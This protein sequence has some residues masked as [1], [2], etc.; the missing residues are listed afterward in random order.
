MAGF[1]R[2]WA[3][4][5]QATRY[6]PATR[7]ERYELLNGLAERLAA[8][9]IAEPFDPA[10]G[11]R[12]GVD[13]V[14]AD[15]ALPESLGATVGLIN[16]RLL[17][18]LGLIGS[19]FRSR[20]TELVAALVTGFA[21]AARDATLEAQDAVR[22]ATLT[23]R[24]EAERAIRAAEAHFRR[25]A[26][27]DP[28]TNLPNRLLFQQRLAELLATP[29]SGTL[30]GVCCVDLDGF[31]RVNDSLGHQVGDRLL[32]A[33]AARLRAL[34]RE[35]HHL[36]ARL[37]GDEFALLVETPSGAERAAKLAD[38]VV[39]ALAEPF[40][41]NGHELPV[42]ASAGVVERPAQGADPTEMLRAANIALHWAKRA[43]GD[44]WTLFDEERSTRDVFRYR[45][46]AA[47]PG[48]LSRG[49]FTLAYQPLVNLADG[50]LVGVEALARWRHPHLGLLGAE[51]FIALAEDTG[52]IVPL[53][54]RLLEQACRQAVWWRRAGVSIP[55]I[56]VN[57]AVRQIHQPGLVATV[58][59]VLDRTGLPASALQLEITESAVIETDRD[60]LHTL[61][62][63][64]D[65]GV[66]LVIDDFG[67]GYANLA[68]LHV[69]PVHGLKLA[70]AFVQSVGRHQPDRRDAF[71]SAVVSLGLT[72]GLTVTAEGI[73]TEEQAKLLRAVGCEIGQGWYFGRPCSP[74]R[75]LPDR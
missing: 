20:L 13:L 9:L 44:Q 58:A 57:L 70:A 6:V 3:Q 16:T 33:V 1:V 35:G 40:Q 17:D 39:A 61:H 18:D 8:G 68:T 62:G 74:R 5:L 11:Y 45:L 12:I 65:L 59:E 23:T 64:A 32:R 60:T 19:L 2:A 53:G 66:R 25:R 31:Q 75:F 26:L 14:A 55:V 30:I 63:L 46:S 10:V 34:A 38:R 41:I 28:L 48:G 50:A 36:L 27:H 21:R 22:L 15:Y 67:T 56:S 37:D 4:A 69:L 73:E 54:L 71:L 52:L 49:E 51:Q 47:M 24:D 72:L 29:P 7:A 42:T 43:G